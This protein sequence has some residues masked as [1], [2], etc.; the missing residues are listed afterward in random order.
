MGRTFV[1]R[2][3]IFYLIVLTFRKI[4]GI[5]SIDANQDYKQKIIDF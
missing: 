5:L 1:A 2:Q 4:N 3:S